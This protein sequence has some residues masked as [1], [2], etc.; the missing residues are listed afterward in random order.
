[1][2]SKP[3]KHEKILRRCPQTEVKKEQY[4]IDLIPQIIVDTTLKEVYEE[5][6][7]QEKK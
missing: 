3:T 4:L 7:K 1:M 2:K 6:S 5:E